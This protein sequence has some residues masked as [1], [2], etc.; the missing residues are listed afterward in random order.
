[1]HM[2]KRLLA[3]PMEKGCVPVSVQLPPHKG[4]SEMANV[5]MMDEAIQSCSES[6]HLIGN[7]EDVPYLLPIL[8]N[9]EGY[10]WSFKVPLP[11]IISWHVPEATEIIFFTVWLCS[12]ILWVWTLTSKSC[13]PSVYLLVH[14]QEAFGR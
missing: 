3:F 8:L 6:Q 7:R 5:W 1:M 4:C 14:F 13:P 10:R 2:G 12:R 11:F 9:C